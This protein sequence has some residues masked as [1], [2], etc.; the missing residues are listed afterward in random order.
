MCLGTLTAVEEPDWPAFMKGDAWKAKQCQTVLSGWAQ[1]RHTWAL[2]AKLNV[3]WMSSSPRPVGFVE[4]VP[5]FYRKLGL[6]TKRIRGVLDDHGA[7]VNDNRPSDDLA[8]DYFLRETLSATVVRIVDIL[9]ILERVEVA[10][11]G[12]E[13][14][15]ALADREKETLHS[16]VKEQNFED[17][18]KFE[19]PEQFI[20]YMDRLRKKS[21][22][23]TKQLDTDVILGSR[24]DD[25]H[26]ICTRLETLSHKQLRNKEFSSTEQSFVQR[27]R[28]D[29]GPPHVLYEEEFLLHTARRCPAHRG[30]LLQ[31]RQTPRKATRICQD[32]QLLY[33]L[34]PWKGK[35]ILS[36]RSRAAIPQSS[37]TANG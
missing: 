6:L 15:K 21:D 11:K 32:L 27:L 36:P 26:E 19:K 1:M 3:N 33:V 16:F 35:D 18:S 34:Y 30:R 28:H 13:G 7:F 23:L 9:E 4:P 31:P 10:T 5:E 12:A 2:Q 37:S 8:K 20:A 14:F 17:P 29:T 22:E 25:L 24:W